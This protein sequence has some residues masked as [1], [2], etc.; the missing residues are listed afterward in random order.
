MPRSAVAAG[1]VDLVLSP[2]EIA[3][4]LFDTF[5]ALRFVDQV[6]LVEQ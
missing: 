3:N 5:G 1:C 2:A 4:E 6:G